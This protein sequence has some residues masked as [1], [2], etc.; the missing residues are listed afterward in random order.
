MMILGADAAGPNPDSPSSAPLLQWMDHYRACAP[1]SR[2]LLIQD[3]LQIA[4]ERRVAMLKLIRT[5]PEQALNT[6][7]DPALFAQLPVAM[8]GLVE[9]SVEGLADSSMFSV[10]SDTPFTSNSRD[11]LIKGR[12]FRAQVY[13]ELAS[14][15]TF[16]KTPVQGIAIG[17]E[18]ALRDMALPRGATLLMRQTLREDH[19]E[20]TILFDPRDLKISRIREYDRI[21]LKDCEL[22][23]DEPGAPALP[24]RFINLLLPAG[25]DV[26]SVQVSSTEKLIA[27]S[28]TPF[29]IQT[30]VPRSE[31]SFSFT[32]PKT[33][34]Y[35]QSDK[36]PPQAGTDDKI[37]RIRGFAMVPVRINPVRYAPSAKEL[38]LA[39]S[40]T[41]VVHYR[42]PAWPPVATVS[43]PQAFESLVEASVLNPSLP[44][45]EPMSTD[46]VW[47]D[48]IPPD[49]PCDYLI[50]T[51]ASLTNAFAQLASHRSAQNGFST[52]VLSVESIEASYDGTR[53][54]GG[55]D[56]QTKIRN[57]IRDYVQ[58][59]ATEYVVLGGDNTI[60]TDRDCFATCGA[61]TSSNMPTDLY[62]AGLDG[63]WDDFDSDGI[64]GEANVASYLNDEGDLNADVWVGRIPVRTVQQ[65]T[66]YIAKVISY[67]LK[68]PY[69]LSRRFMMGG[70][71]L[72]NSYTNTERP[73]DTMPDG[74]M[75]FTHAAHPIVSDAEMWARRTFRDTVQAYGWDA[76]RIGCTF[77]TLTSWDSV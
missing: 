59:R 58:T 27:E 45:A 24:A 21:E 61:Y 75:A 30:P 20:Q 19:V 18:M 14:L 12:L 68:P 77:D 2:D 32:E 43:S 56:I 13:G 5:D 29:P 33:E 76:S 35:N 22:P 55:S 51:K 3:G 54:D 31:S 26:V 71:L 17:Q 6:A 9:S 48:D 67:E 60:V 66:T 34:V 23:E 63:N 64:Y 65:T 42:Q 62:F 11:L 41:V 8:Q 50:I 70:L 72:W 74:H 46:P 1:E 15:A 40:V 44:E 57:C 38:Y 53:P 39:E 7:L 37:R 49:P 47:M 4:R 16:R 10:D 52:E 28:I 69:A 73:T 25:A 36:Y